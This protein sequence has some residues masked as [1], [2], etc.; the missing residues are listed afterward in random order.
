[1]FL[2][3]KVPLFP[4][5]HIAGMYLLKIGLFKSVICISISSI[6]FNGLIA[7]FLMVTA[8]MKSEDDCFLAGKL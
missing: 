7:H 1:M 3:S 4:E 8:V 2:V 6:S 5:S